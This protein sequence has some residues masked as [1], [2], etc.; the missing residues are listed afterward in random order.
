MAPFKAPPMLSRSPRSAL[1]H[2]AA[3]VSFVL[4]AMWFMGPVL[5]QPSSLAIGHPN[6]DV[7]NHVWG[8]GFVA[9]SLANGEWPLHTDLLNW[10]HGGTLWFIDLVGALMTLPINWMSGPVAAY[11]A[12][13]LI[14]WVLAG[15]GMYA[16]AWRVTGSAAGAWA[17]G[18]AFQTMP[19]LMGQAYNGISETL[20]AGFLPL[21]LLGLREL[22]HA[23]SKRTAIWAGL[24]LGVTALANWY[25]GLFAGIVLLGLIGRSMWRTR[26]RV[27]ASAQR[28]VI[29]FALTVIAVA[30]PAFFAFRA[31]MSAVDAVVTRDPQFVWAT[32]VLHNMTDLVSFFRPGKHYSPDLKEAFGEDLI[33]VVY[34]GHALL[35]PALIGFRS[36]FRARMKSWAAMALGFFLLALGPFLFIA[37]DYVSAFGG[38]IPLPFL[39]LFKWTPMFSRISHAYRFSVGVSLALCMLLAWSIRSLRG[40]GKPVWLFAII[41]AALRIGESTMASPAHFPLPTA[42]ATVSAAVASLDGG[43]VLDLP[44]GRPVLARSQYSLGQLAHGQPSPY[45]LNDPLPQSLRANRFLRFLV[46]MEYSTTATLPAQLPWF[47]LEMGRL[48]AIEDGLKWI[49]MHEASYPSGQYARTARFLDI[50]ATPVHYGEGV[51]IYRLEP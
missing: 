37:G 2:F 39:A 42:T 7:W 40:S 29:P 41:I 47:D 26:G 33:V 45:G 28:C 48:A 49:V 16:L 36:D 14:Q 43:A 6:N 50:A 25:Y 1:P 3:L 38:W 13:M 34:L 24:G 17:A 19:H 44:V 8:Y 5:S 10:P 51:R 18:I 15:A 30:A 12:S 32:L 21:A 20:M 9:Q 4:L 23:P 31:S 11:N 46:E 35:W 22:F 27:T